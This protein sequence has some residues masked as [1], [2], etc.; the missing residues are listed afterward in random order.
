MKKGIISQGKKLNKEEL[1]RISGGLGNVR[2]TNSSNY[3]IYIG[4]GCRE[5]KCQLPEPLEAIE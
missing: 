1:S 2:C 4:P 3:C 5:L